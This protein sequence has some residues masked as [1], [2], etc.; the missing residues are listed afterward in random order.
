[1]DFGILS[2]RF[3][4]F[5]LK[6]FSSSKHSNNFPLNGQLKKALEMICKTT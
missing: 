3:K 1:M 2:L 5:N 6:K 4:F